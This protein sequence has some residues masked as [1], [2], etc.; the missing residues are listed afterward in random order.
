M[1]PTLSHLVYRPLPGKEA[2]LAQ[3]MKDYTEAL[4]KAGFTT[5][6]SPAPANKPEGYLVETFEWIDN[7][8]DLEDE[9]GNHPEVKAIRD[10]MMAISAIPDLKEMQRIAKALKG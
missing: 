4:H 8:E 2:E 1:K 7:N 9:A 10:K 5:G 3:L 6:N